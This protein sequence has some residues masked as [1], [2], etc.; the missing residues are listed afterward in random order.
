MINKTLLEATAKWIVQDWKDE[1]VFPDYL[2]NAPDELKNKI[3]SYY[4]A[5]TLKSGD[6]KKAF[7]TSEMFGMEILNEVIEEAKNYI[8][9]NGKFG[10][11]RKYL[12]K[13]DLEAFKEYEIEFS[14]SEALN[15][16]KLQ[17]FKFDE[18]KEILNF[19]KDK[20]DPLGV[21]LNLCEDFCNLAIDQND[22]EKFST[23]FHM[24]LEV[25]TPEKALS[26]LPN[27]NSFYLRDGEKL[28]RKFNKFVALFKKKRVNDLSKKVESW[29]ES[30]LAFYPE[31]L[32]KKD[33]RDSSYTL[34]RII[35]SYLKYFKFSKKTS[36]EIGY[37]LISN[38]LDISP[39]KALEC[40]GASKNK[41]MKQRLE[42]FTVAWKKAQSLS[43]KET[44][45]ILNNALK[46]AEK[47]SKE[48]YHLLA[49]SILES[50]QSLVEKNNIPFSQ[51]KQMIG[52]KVEM[53]LNTLQ[54]TGKFPTR[55]HQ[56]QTIIK[57]IENIDNKKISVD[58]IKQVIK[59]RP[60]LSEEFI[61]DFFSRFYEL[62]D[63]RFIVKTINGL[64]ENKGKLSGD[65]YIFKL[66]E[67]LNK[68]FSKEELESFAN[69]FEKSKNYYY[70]LKIHKLLDPDSSKTVE[71]LEKKYS[72][73]HHFE[74]TWE[75]NKL[76]AKK[77]RKI[78]DILEKQEVEEKNRKIPEID[79][80]FLMGELENRKLCIPNPKI[81]NKY[82]VKR[83]M[84]GTN[85]FKALYRFIENIAILKTQ[86]RDVNLDVEIPI[87]LN[88]IYTFPLPFIKEEAPPREISKRE[89][90]VLV[91]FDFGPKPRREARIRWLE[92]TLLQKIL[93]KYHLLRNINNKD[94]PQTYMCYNEVPYKERSEY[95]FQIIED[96]LKDK[97]K[98]KEINY[99]ILNKFQDDI[100]QEII[101]VFL[102]HKVK[103]K[104]T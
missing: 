49:F 10:C 97:M 73:L 3:I 7:H 47:F 85:E 72:N 39:W 51:I 9:N 68:K 88:K 102:H 31:L 18:L 95:F 53:A 64:I 22:L 13:E 58:I 87:N 14:K 94:W 36:D 17:Y 76:L 66:L 81:P 63:K 75:E 103:P 35:E 70:A 6:A 8:I 16:L 30:I 44:D 20:I 91:T 4:L 19:Y 79:E 1:I 34:G 55:Y 67:N 74:L 41:K 23:G 89:D 71:Q 65:Y 11:K 25:S 92:A 57:D 32:K 29:F 5:W 84:S 61:C 83:K 40:F 33:S 90:D 77:N 101:K 28:F 26:L 99:S 93:L 38:N 69:S 86:I 100:D 59:S 56:P 62:F 2:N 50:A 21:Y 24:L 45:N 27:V 98:I 48:G 54:D 78:K 80:K 60:F 15:L 37:A 52:K 42:I 46:E 82:D 104:A 96:F 12:I 43:Q